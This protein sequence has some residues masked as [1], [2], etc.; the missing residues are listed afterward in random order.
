MISDDVSQ[1]LLTWIKGHF[2]G[3]YRGTVSDNADPTHRG[4]LKVKVPAVLGSVESW[5][6]PCVPYAGQ[7]VGLHT[8][9]EQGMGVWVEFEAGDPSYPVWTGC[10]WAD[11]QLPSDHQ[12]AQAKS[13]LKII[14][15]ESGMIVALDDDQQTL[16]LSDSA[17][18]N[19]IAMTMPQGHIKIQSTVKVVVEAPMIDLV[20]NAVHPIMFGDDLLQYLNQLVMMFNT[21]LHP[22]EMALGVFPVTP[23]IPQPLWPFP[24][25]SMLSTKVKNG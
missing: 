25:P 7:G 9:P 21:H 10:F 6:M 15:S 12:G 22:G 5:A 2:F 3:K 20:E 13:A 18:N 23:M 16:T 8:L 4:R 11:D 19:L 1:D 24:S 14:R 17:G